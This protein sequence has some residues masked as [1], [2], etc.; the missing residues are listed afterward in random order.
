M[1]STWPISCETLRPP[2][3]GEAFPAAG[4]RVAPDRPEALHRTSGCVACARRDRAA[5]IDSP[6]ALGAERRNRAPLRLTCTQV[7]CRTRARRL[8]PFA[9]ASEQAHRRRPADRDVLAALAAILL[10]TRADTKPPV[11]TRNLSDALVAL[12]LQG[13]RSFSRLYPALSSMNVELGQLPRVRRASAQLELQMGRRCRRPA[14]GAIS[15]SVLST[16][17]RRHVTTPDP[18]SHVHDGRRPERESGSTEAIAHASGS[19]GT[20]NVVNDMPANQFLSAHHRGRRSLP[21]NTRHQAR[22]GST[23]PVVTRPDRDAALY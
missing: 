3:Q 22:S 23:R 20:G 16:R 18:K 21:A 4:L 13:Q 19:I 2:T 17:V 12:A 5:A 9:R 15:S 14:S 8:E 1:R 10:R 7:A 6:V 11:D